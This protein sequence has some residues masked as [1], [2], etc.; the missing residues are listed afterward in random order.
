LH[1]GVERRPL[2]VQAAC[3]PPLED[4]HSEL[5]VANLAAPVIIVAIE[6]LGDLGRLHRGVHLLQ[7]RLHFVD[8]EVPGAIRIVLVERGLNRG[9]VPRG[10]RL[11]PNESFVHAA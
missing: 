8:V 1:D 9:V 5:V 4:K 2:H 3:C 7:H 6:E 10:V 11:V